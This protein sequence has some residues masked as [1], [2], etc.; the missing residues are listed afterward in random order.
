MSADGLVT[1]IATQADN[2]FAGDDNSANDVYVSD[3]R[4][5][6]TCR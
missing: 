1:L 4:P 3:P 2:L 6:P 5:A